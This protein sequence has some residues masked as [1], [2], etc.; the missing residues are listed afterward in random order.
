MVMK[1]KTVK[2]FS[3]RN[4]FSQ[5]DSR[6]L[7]ILLFIFAS[8]MII[9]AGTAGKSDTFISSQMGG[10]VSD[11]F[12]YCVKSGF[13]KVFFYSFII[14]ALL[15]LFAFVNGFN[16]I[17]LPLSVVLPAIKGIGLGLISGSMYTAGSS[18]VIR[19]CMTILPG[20]IFAVLALIL[21]CNESAYMSVDILS[22]ILNRRETSD[23]ISIKKYSV[24][25]LIILLIVF[26]SSIIDSITLVGIGHYL[27]V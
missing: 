8:A 3:K 5:T 1:I 22:L 27:S 20:G 18:G 7:M 13:V 21:A 11:A 16:C 15:I 12:D 19:Y 9:G 6:S 24:K 17:G 25:F 26:I 10:Y 2:Y 23:N 4:A 14:N